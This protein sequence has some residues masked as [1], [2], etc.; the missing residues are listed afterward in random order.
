MTEHVVQVS[1]LG[2][3]FNRCAALQNVSLEIPRGVVWGLVG[4][5]GA[6]KTT[7]LRHMLGLLRAQ[8]GTVRVFGYDPVTSPVQVL[9]KI[10]YLSEERDL[11]DWMR[12]DELLS[13]TR[14]F[15]SSWDPSLAHSLLEAF[16]LPRRQKVKTLSR[17]ERARTGLLLA[18]AHRP[19]LL[20]LDEPSTG[21]DPA[22]RRD[23]LSAI[24][25]TVADE[26]RTV[27]FSSHLL[28]E[29][30]RVADHV[31]M[32][33][34]GQ[35]ILSSTMEGLLCTHI[36]LI[37]RF[38]HPRTQAP[39][40]PGALS[41]VGEGQEWTVV[42][43]GRQQEVLDRVAQLDGEIVDRHIPSLDEVFLAYCRAEPA[44]EVSHV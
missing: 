36:R 7:L 27:L 25:R 40:L 35:V 12:I 20:L 11:P 4:E 24:I 10:G 21:L 13:Y 26:G 8:T 30:Q 22:V 17:G 31:T 3:T 41:C 32:L 29:V 19:P 42:C 2:R 5:N 23:I 28:D 37:V 38:S 34:R 6:G 33:H 18:L 15:Y 16:H 43:N 9:S 1:G 44:A 39:E 14:C